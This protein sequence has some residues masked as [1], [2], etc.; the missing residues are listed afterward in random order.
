MANDWWRTYY[1]TSGAQ[2]E[3]LMRKWALYTRVSAVCKLW[4]TVFDWCQ[5]F[6]FHDPS[7]LEKYQ[8]INILWWPFQ[9]LYVILMENIHV[10]IDLGLQGKINVRTL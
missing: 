6:A 7:M 10:S 9:S 4:Y 8:F 3:L 2:A 5:T 1:S